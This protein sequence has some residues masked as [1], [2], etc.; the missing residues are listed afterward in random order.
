MSHSHSSLQVQNPY[1]EHI[2]GQLQNPFTSP[3]WKMVHVNIQRH[4][5]NLT[6]YLVKGQSKCQIWNTSRQ[7]SEYPSERATHRIITARRLTGRRRWKWTP[8]SFSYAI[9]GI[10]VRSFSAQAWQSQRWPNYLWTA[11]A[12]E[13][14]WLPATLLVALIRLQLNYLF[15]NGI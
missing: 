2:L 10:A 4:I 13:T 14:F 5:Y 15:I 12:M 6:L 9:S 1:I 11:L 3:T 8:L 7:H